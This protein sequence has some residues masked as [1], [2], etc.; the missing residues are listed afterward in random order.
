[1]SEVLSRRSF[2]KDAAV[3]GTAVVAVGLPRVLRAADKVPPILEGAFTEDREKARGGRLIDANDAV[4][5]DQDHTVAV[6]SLRSDGRVERVDLDTESGKYE[7]EP[8]SLQVP[9]RDAQ[10][11]VG[12]AN[13]DEP[14]NEKVVVAGYDGTNDL[15]KQNAVISI[16]ADSGRTFGPAVTLMN[17]SGR[18]YIGRVNETE[19]IPNL[20]QALLRASNIYDNGSQYYIYDADTDELKL[21]YAI[22]EDVPLLDNLSVDPDD[23]STLY[24]S[25]RVVSQWEGGPYTRGIADF[26]LDLEN[27][28]ITDGSHRLEKH[29][30]KLEDMFVGDPRNGLDQDMYALQTVTEP[31][32][33]PLRLLHRIKKEDQKDYDIR[34]GFDY[35]FQLD[36]MAKDLLKGVSGFY[37]EAV[38][39]DMITYFKNIHVFPQGHAW[40]TGYYS[41]AI[42][43]SLPLAVFMPQVNLENPLD[44]SQIFLFPDLLSFPSEIKQKPEFVTF[45][46]GQ[47]LPGKDESV[48][49]VVFNLEAGRTTMIE[50][51]ENHVP[52]SGDIWYQRPGESQDQALQSIPPRLVS[53]KSLKYDPQRHFDFINSLKE[54]A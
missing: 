49:G 1:M 11:I 48:H 34:E 51:D 26:T 17:E 33:Y 15:R 18:S 52:L 54:T 41:T 12:F 30:M 39:Y 14:G 29:F 9:M 32:Y 31:G 22:S 7:L 8:N 43:G 38:K 44:D 16:S 6:Y 10:K 3:A 27:H 42:A 28:V 47:N 45:W 36:S 24:G 23:K 40:A 5:D 50:T 2:V 37:D 21:V 13:H 53:I 20:N 19:K 25:G 35:G 4:N 46:S